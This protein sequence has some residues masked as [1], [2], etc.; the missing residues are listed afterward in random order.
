MTNIT[1]YEAQKKLTV[2]WFIA[3]AFLIFI[4]V[5]WLITGAI[6]QIDQVIMWVVQN[7]VPYL[8]L[9]TTTFIIV[10]SRGVKSNTDVIDRFFLRLSMIVSLFYFLLLIAIM[11]SL[12]YYK[13][14]NMGTAQEVLNKSNK[15]LPFIQS[16]VTGV[17]GVFFIKKK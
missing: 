14:H 3:S 17:L 7:V 8:T 5:V 1:R 10:Y 9:I 6:D 2:L 13:F 11:I 15:I 16:V 4:V 12:P